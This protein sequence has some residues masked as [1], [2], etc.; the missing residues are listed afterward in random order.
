MRKL[1]ERERETGESGF[2]LFLICILIWS[3]GSGNHPTKYIISVARP[4]SEKNIY[5]YPNPYP[6]IYVWAGGRAIWAGGSGWTR[7]CPPLV[8]LIEGDH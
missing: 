1:N 5:I 7:I 4:K 2:I 6:S 3:G 8:L